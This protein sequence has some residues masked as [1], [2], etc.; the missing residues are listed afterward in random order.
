M[1]NKEETKTITDPR[2]IPAIC[3]MTYVFLPLF[4][5]RFWEK[6][7]SYKV[8]SPWIEKRTYKVTSSDGK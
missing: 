6:S 7:N 4:C 5:Y 3:S 1:E 8:S 2:L